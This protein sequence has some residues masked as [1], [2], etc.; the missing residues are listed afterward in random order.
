MDEGEANNFP[1]PDGGNVVGSRYRHKL[2]SRFRKNRKPRYSGDGEEGN[3]DAKT[4]EAKLNTEEKKKKKNPRNQRKN[5]TRKP[6]AHREMLILRL[7]PNLQT[8]LL[9]LP[10]RSHGGRFKN[11]SSQFDRSLSADVSARK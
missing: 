9:A 2:L 11:K 4:K 8:L 6:K 7:S 1:G 10:I 5:R 3:A